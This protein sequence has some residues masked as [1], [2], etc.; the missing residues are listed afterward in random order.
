MIPDITNFSFDKK[1]KYSLQLDNLRMLLDEISDPCAIIDTQSGKI[2]LT[3]YRF[4]ELSQYPISDL[5]GA[6]IRDLTKSFEYKEWPDGF[7]AEIDINRKKDVDIQTQAKF[8]YLDQNANLALICLTPNSELDYFERSLLALVNSQLL[9][10][11]DLDNL[12]KNKFINEI[13]KTG[14]NDFG[15][16]Y[17][18]LYL[19]EE[20][21]NELKKYS[22][23]KDQFPE[24]LSF[25]ELNRIGTFDFWEPGKRVLTEIHRVG[26]AEKIQSIFSIPIKMFGNQDGILIVGHKRSK[27]GVILKQL[28]IYF[29]AWMSNIS[30]YL[31]QYWDVLH[32]YNKTKSRSELLQRIF[33]NANDSFI[34]LD[35][36]N[37][38]IDF[39]SNFCKLF[40][41]SPIELLNKRAD[42]IL[43]N[44][45]KK[46]LFALEESSEPGTPA[47]IYFLHD[48]GG[49]ELPVLINKISFT[50]S[51]GQDTILVI[52]NAKD[53]IA[54]SKQ[55]EELEKKAA[56]GEVI[57]DF[58]HEVRNPMNSITTGLQLITHEMDTGSQNYDVLNRMQEDC[59]RID[60]LME[61]VL[62]F[63]RQKTENFI[64]LDL[65]QLINRIVYQMKNKIQKNGHQL[66]FK[67]NVDSPVVM[68]DQRSLEQV[69]INLIN[70]SAEAIVEKSGVIAIYLKTPNEYPEHYQISI[71][72]TGLGIPKQIEKRLFEPFVTAKPKGTGLG[73]AITK[74]I[75][76]SHNGRIEA[77]T[78][79][80]GTI[81]HVYLPILTE[82][83]K[84]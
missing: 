6:D 20:D 30:K 61:S 81:F 71:A 48:R 65:N 18:A 72:D 32:N 46:T 15:A 12:T 3:N 33:E 13:L 51:N 73:L 57:A 37:H 11:R 40:S 31:M 17:F 49:N 83:V 78:F 53:L 70:N 54:D 19:L 80:G 28:L 25:I 8:R 64:N 36:K 44:V 68:A 10:I 60:Y 24:S 82:G 27:S 34:I 4:S 55:K 22:F 16:D 29:S 69:I 42:L 67:S 43:G 39:N 26:R 1:N 75:I 23:I 63:S 52:R 38:I 77:E 84:E 35:K 56:L 7:S 76:D 59:L 21:R 66:I 2:V 41:Y 62:S 50:S 5:I 47:Q 74:R 58:A 45:F 79:P 9:I 14:K